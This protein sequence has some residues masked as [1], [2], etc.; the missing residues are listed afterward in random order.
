VATQQSITIKL[1]NTET[2]SV[3]H[4][5]ISMLKIHIIVV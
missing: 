3:L 4:N 1:I 2:E 5:K